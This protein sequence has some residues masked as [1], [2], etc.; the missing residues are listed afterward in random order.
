M[1]QYLVTMNVHSIVTMKWH[2]L[3]MICRTSADAL[4]S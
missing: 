4:F 1:S 3:V 2:L